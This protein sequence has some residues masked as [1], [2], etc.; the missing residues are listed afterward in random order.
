MTDK[1]PEETVSRNNPDDELLTAFLD[2]ELSEAVEK[3]KAL[4]AG[5]KPS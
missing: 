3:I 4:I 1:I 2:G 5:E